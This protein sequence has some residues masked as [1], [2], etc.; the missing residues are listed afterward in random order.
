MMWQIVSVVA[1][2]ILIIVVIAVIVKPTPGIIDGIYG[3]VGIE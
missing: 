1:L 3:L 2:I